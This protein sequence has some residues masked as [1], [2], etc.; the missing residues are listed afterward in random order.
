MRIDIEFYNTAA[1]VAWAV[2][3]FLIA[4]MSIS[5]KRGR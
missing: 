4:G 1:A 3:V 2:A 5:R